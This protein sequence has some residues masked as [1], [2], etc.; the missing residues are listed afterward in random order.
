M[1]K[2]TAVLLVF[3]LTITYFLSSCSLFDDGKGKDL[4][5]PIYSDT[6]SFD[7]QIAEDEASSI[8]CVNCFEGL[9]KY[10]SEGNIVPGVAKSWEISSDGL[11][12]IF[13]LD[14]NAKWNMNSDA[15][16]ILLSYTIDKFNEKVTADDFVFG[17]RRYF[18]P[19]M[20]TKSD[21]RLYLIENAFDVADGS[22]ALSKLGVKAVDSN[23]LQIKLSSKSD[24]FL[25]ALTS[26]AAMPCREEFFLATKGRYGLDAKYIIC[27]GPFY[28]AYHSEST[29]IQ[30]KK[31]ENYFL[32]DTVCP[33]NVYLYINTDEVSRINKL[34]TNVY[35][36]CPINIEQKQ[37]IKEKKISFK[38]YQNSTWGFCFNCSDE[39]L[40][41]KDLRVAICQSIDINT[42]EIPSYTTGIAQGIVPDVCTLGEK[43]YRK[44]AGKAEFLEFSEINAKQSFDSAMDSLDKSVISLTLICPADLEN[45]MRRLIQNWQKNLGMSLEIKIEPMTIDEI[46]EKIENDDYQIAFSYVSSSFSSTADFLDMFTHNN[47][48]ECFNYTSLSYTNA[49][50]DASKAVN[51][52]DMTKKCLKAENMLLQNGVFYPA[53]S[54][55]SF[56]ALAKGVCDV[57]FTYAGTIPVFKNGKRVS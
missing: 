40:A 51:V 18:D 17:L 20:K 35:D 32:K 11:T 50:I 8:V 43:S 42:L 12:Y 3:V 22:K 52:K 46:N 31:N 19:Q 48:F 23:T 36:A 56:L 15:K 37:G 38:A 55:E 13:H 44:E 28:L 10:D 5:Y 29:Y 24:T 1:K 27:N 53:F 14:E 26:G 2:A 6:S 25:G 47:E 7:P 9:V 33:A 54:E 16:E 41:N 45:D 39:M 49:V 30:M 34:E 57:Y 4:Y 21:A